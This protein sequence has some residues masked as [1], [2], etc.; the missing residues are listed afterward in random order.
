MVEVRLVGLI[1]HG[2]DLTLKLLYAV[3]LARAIVEKPFSVGG[4]TLKRTAETKL[5]RLVAVGLVFL[6]LLLSV[7]R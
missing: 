3:Y 7:S 2:E 6:Y 1:I 4:K 5:D